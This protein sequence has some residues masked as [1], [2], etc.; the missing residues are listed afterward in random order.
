MFK[1]YDVFSK[2]DK[3]IIRKSENGRFV[4][5]SDV[6]ARYKLLANFTIPGDPK[7][8]KNN[9]IPIIYRDKRKPYKQFFKHMDIGFR[10][11]IIPSAIFTKYQKHALKHIP[12][13]AKPFEEINLKVLYYR[14]TRRKIDLV[15]LLEA[16][17]DILVKAEFIK[18][19]DSKCVISTDGSRVFYDKT[20]PRTEIFIERIFIPDKQVELKL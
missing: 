13:I 14:E 1:K 12:Q 10:I 16:T 11:L 4:L 5:Y 8:K 15:N 19:D 18:D 6:S 20:N 2:A 17:C 7:P 9:P 3:P